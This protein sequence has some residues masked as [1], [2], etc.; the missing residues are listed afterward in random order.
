M[1]VP[2]ARR[3]RP[4]IDA[5]VTI[6]LGPFEMPS[7]RELR[8]AVGALAERYPWSRLTWRP[9]QR[10]RYWL[11]D[12]S[13]ESIVIERPWGGEF[14]LGK[15]LDDLALDHSLETPLILIRYPNCL[16]LRMSHGLGDGRAFLTV[17]SAVL[18]TAMTDAVVDW[19]AEPAG[20]FPL[21]TAAW[22][23]FGRHPS[24]VVR[25]IRDRPARESKTSSAIEK[26]W[27]P[28][29]HTVHRTISRSTTDELFAWG[30]AAAPGANAFGLKAAALLIAF[31]AAGLEV[32]QD[33]RVVA[34]LR[35]YLDWR[36][37]DGNFLAGVPVRLNASMTPEHISAVVKTMSRSGRPLAG[38]MLTAMRGGVRM[39]S[40]T[41]VAPDLLPTVTFSDLGKSPELNRLSF[42]PD[43]PRLFAGSAPPEGPL[44]LTVFMSETSQG[45]TLNA[46]F[47]DNVVD[48]ERVTAAL[49]MVATDP[50]ALLKPSADAR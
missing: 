42:L 44:G 40:P 9:D 24:A 12:R 41:T 34:D 29:R 32:S 21:V 13:P 30:K 18:L 1:K 15:R 17:M 11:H 3:D 25:A 36:Y 46:T 19:P 7:L 49:D 27:Q 2:V 16:G 48:P 35:R 8:D 6:L 31:R 28:S 38:Q 5:H 22:R 20:R 43:G 47:H 39:E 37:I 50:I 14:N 23:T 4:W 33:V 45:V 10:A 26:P